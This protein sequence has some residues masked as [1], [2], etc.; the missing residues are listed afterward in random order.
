MKESKNLRE[1]IDGSN[2]RVRNGAE[3]PME[4]GLITFS[5]TEIVVAT[6]RKTNSRRNFSMAVA[7]RWSCGCRRIEG[8][9]IKSS[10]HRE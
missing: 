6:N 2:G 7:S 5:D 1:L 8:Q 4:A 3:S 10:R 9:S